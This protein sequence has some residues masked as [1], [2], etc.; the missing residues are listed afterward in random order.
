MVAVGNR[1]AGDDAAGPLVLDAVRDD[2]PAGVV[3]RELDGEPARLLDAWDGLDAVVVVDAASSG[4]PVG[5][6]HR[7]AVEPRGPS[8]IGPG[9][10]GRRRSSHGAGVAEALGLGRLLGRLPGE[11]VVV[12]VEG[13][14]FSAGT[15]LSR[16]VAAALPGAAAVVRDEVGRLTGAPGRC[17]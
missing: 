2:L 9:P 3:A 11:V 10:P 1:F 13:A 4:E 17:A 6:V 14:R 5:T 15:T 16:A 8:G 7:L 12:G